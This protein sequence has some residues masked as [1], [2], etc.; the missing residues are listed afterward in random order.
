MVS[1]G[2][3]HAALETLRLFRKRALRLLV[4]QEPLALPKSVHSVLIGA[5]DTP[6]ARQGFLR[7]ATVLSTRQRPPHVTSLQ[8]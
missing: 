6:A 5:I 1:Q 8:A 3:R 2:R 7:R 4:R